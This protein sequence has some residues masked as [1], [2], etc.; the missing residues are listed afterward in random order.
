MPDDLTVS[1]A[2]ELAA[3]SK[4]L[5]AAGADGLRREML[6]GLRAGAKPLTTVARRSALENL[7]R[8]GGLNEVVAAQKFAVRTRTSGSNPGVR[9]VGVSKRHLTEL[10]QGRLRH[11]TFGHKPWVTQK[12]KPGWWSE[13]LK[14]EAPKVRAALLRQLAETARKIERG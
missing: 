4:R 11:P 5:R 9:V 14:G 2:N 8:K 7:P 12:V 10:D 3:V 1:G 6:R 13:A